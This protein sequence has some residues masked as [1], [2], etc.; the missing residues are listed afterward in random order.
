[1]KDYYKILGVAPDCSQED[2]KKAYR[3]LARG[4][5]PDTCGEKDSSKFREVQE[6]YDAIGSADKRQAYDNSL[7]EDQ[8]HV[9]YRPMF[10]TWN[11][12]R[13][14]FY[15]ASIENFFEQMLGNV[16][17][18]NPFFQDQNEIDHELELILT[19]DEARAGLIIPVT[20]PVRKNCPVCG[21]TFFS[22]FSFCD[23]CQGAGHIVRD[24][25]AKVEIPPQVR[26]NSR[27]RISIHE[28]GILTIKIF[29]R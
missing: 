3:K 7:N 10:A 25:T 12:E 16:L 27:F 22:L 11:N 28:A 26:N 15:P 1:M 13:G 19:A 2:I 5:H 24:I 14:P 21:G 20:I 29:I 9:Y 18:S 4:S 6:A 23:Y 8:R 17:H